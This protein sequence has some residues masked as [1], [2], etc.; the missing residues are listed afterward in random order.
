[1]A[2]TSTQGAPLTLDR[3]QEAKTPQEAPLRDHKLSVALYC[4]IARIDYLEE[5]SQAWLDWVARCYPAP[6]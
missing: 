3:S 4:S 1:M 6:V 5:L 2:A